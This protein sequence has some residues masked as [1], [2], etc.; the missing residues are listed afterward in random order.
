QWS[1]LSPTRSHRDHAFLTRTIHA[2]ARAICIHVS[3]SLC[4]RRIRGR[5]GSLKCRTK[6][7]PAIPTRHS[8]L[9]LPLA[10][11]ISLDASTLQL[12]D[13]KAPCRNQ[14]GLGGRVVTGFGH[15]RRPDV[16]GPCGSWIVGNRKLRLLSTSYR[17]WDTQS[18]CNGVIR[19]GF[20]I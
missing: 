19:S 17:F 13:P 2:L 15:A 10:K 14:L 8:G 5:N 11:P 12:A 1:D 3:A 16:L 9:Q 18:G 20:A 7:V 6:F 4:V